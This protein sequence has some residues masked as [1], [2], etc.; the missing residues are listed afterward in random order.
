MTETIFGETNLRAGDEVEVIGV[1]DHEVRPEAT[2]GG[3]GA[4]LHPVLRA[5]ESTP[6]LVERIGE[7]QSDAGGEPDCLSIVR[8]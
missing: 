6:L 2:G 4:R 8:A 5:T 7:V 1:L 3:R